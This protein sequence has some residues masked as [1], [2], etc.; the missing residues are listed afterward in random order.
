[1]NIPNIPDF[2]TLIPHDVNAIEEV[3]INY[4]LIEEND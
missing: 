1:M 3:K 2:A 4:N